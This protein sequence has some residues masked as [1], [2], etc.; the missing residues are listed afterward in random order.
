M[1]NTKPSNFKKK[2][3]FE[4]MRSAACLFIVAIHVYTALFNLFNKVSFKTWLISDV[5]MSISRFSVPL[6]IMITGA[7]LLEK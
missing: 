1:K 4:L 6:F 3:S 5:I 7:L 2:I